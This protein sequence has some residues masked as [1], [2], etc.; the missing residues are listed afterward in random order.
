MKKSVSTRIKITKNGK[1]VTRKM[2]LCHFRAKKTGQQ[3]M[4]KSR[5]GTLEAGIAKKVFKKQGEF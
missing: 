5:P 3:R 2:A 1:V 4:R